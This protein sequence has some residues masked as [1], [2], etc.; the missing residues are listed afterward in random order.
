[1]ELPDGLLSGAQVLL[2]EKTTQALGLTFHELATNALKYGDANAIGGLKVDWRFEGRGAARKLVLNW[3]ES[4]QE[5]LEAPSKV[6]FGTKLIDMNITRELHGTIRRDFQ[7][8]GLK[9]RI[10]LP[11]PA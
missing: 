3:R 4:G 11:M 9:V 1:K 8:D 5:A 10:D 6:G 2:D 7:P